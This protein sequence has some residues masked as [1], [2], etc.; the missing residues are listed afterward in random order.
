[1]AKVFIPS[2]PYRIERDPATNKPKR[3]PVTGEVIKHAA[4]DITVAS[5]YGR[6]DDEP[7]F[8][9]HGVPPAASKNNVNQVRRRLRDFDPDEDSIIAVGDPVAVA[10]CCAVAVRDFGGFSILRWDGRTR[11]Y[12]KMAFSI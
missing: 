6:I 4:V 5:I 8:N 3:D 12:V 1:M 9:G 2:I 10:L 11:Q 7:I